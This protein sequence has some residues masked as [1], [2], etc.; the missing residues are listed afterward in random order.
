MIRYTHS[1]PCLESE[2]FSRMRTKSHIGV[3]LIQPLSALL[4]AESFN[5]MKANHIQSVP[6][7][8]PCVAAESKGGH[9]VI[10]P[11]TTEFLPGPMPLIRT[12]TLLRASNKLSLLTHTQ[13]ESANGKLH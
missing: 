13:S 9:T 8:E 3:S 10:R 5:S 1:E 12:S 4:E 7:I 11:R 6:L 2:L